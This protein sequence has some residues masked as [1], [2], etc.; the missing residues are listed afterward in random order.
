MSTLVASTTLK[1][2]RA[3]AATVEGERLN[4]E[5]TDGRRIS[6]PLGW[7]EWLAAA[8][9]KDQCAFRLIGGGEGL[10]WDTLDDGISVPL[11]LGVPEFATKPSLSRYPVEY[12]REGRRWIAEIPDLESST[13][14]PTLAAAQA[15]ARGVLAMLL[16][17]ADLESA[18][19]DVLDVV[20]SEQPI[21]KD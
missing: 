11:L 10:W 9:E 21:D 14:G 15:E 17:V 20:A 3:A 4:V 18:G 16:G 13:W 12:R 1:R 2:P 8:S 19:I 5:L 6:V 7:F